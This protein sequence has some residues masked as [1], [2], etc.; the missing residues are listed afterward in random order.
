MCARF[1]EEN[2]LRISTLNAKALMPRGNLNGGF[3]SG[4]A[5]RRK[6]KEDGAV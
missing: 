3:A 1:T 5:Q 2:Q 6:K 4:R